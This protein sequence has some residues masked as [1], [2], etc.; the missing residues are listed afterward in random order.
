MKGNLQSL[1]KQPPGLAASTGRKDSR[2]WSLASMHTSG[3]NSV[4][5]TPKNTASLPPCFNQ[6]SS[7]VVPLHSSSSNNLIEQMNRD[8][9]NV[10][11]GQKEFHDQTE[12]IVLSAKESC[13]SLKNCKIDENQFTGRLS[14]GISMILLFENRIYF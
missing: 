10:Q 1:T 9:K 11:S 12:K 5:N 6:E 4:M 14:F 7:S 8:N 2:R 3:F 13:S